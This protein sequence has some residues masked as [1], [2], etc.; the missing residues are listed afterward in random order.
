MRKTFNRKLPH[1]NTLNKW[2]STVDGSPGFTQEALQA[3]KVKRN[4]ALS[5]NKTLL[6][7]MVIDEMSI[8]Q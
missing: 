8:R 7:N 6:C 3:L 4:E 1:I 2:Y 5:H